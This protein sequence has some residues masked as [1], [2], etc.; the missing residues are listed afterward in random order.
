[1]KDALVYI[2]QQSGRHFDPRL[3]EILVRS[4]DQVL[5]VGERFA[6]QVAE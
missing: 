3:V 6:D 1:V 2:E 5:A 4:A